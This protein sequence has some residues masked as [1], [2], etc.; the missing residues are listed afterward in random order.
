M[1]FDNIYANLSIIPVSASHMCNT[2]TSALNEF[3]FM[4]YLIP[5][6]LILTPIVFIG[7]PKASHASKL[8]KNPFP[9][10]NHQV[11][12]FLSNEFRI[13][14]LLSSSSICSHHHKIKHILP[15]LF[16]FDGLHFLPITNLYP[17]F[18]KEFKYNTFD[19]IFQC[20]RMSLLIL[21]CE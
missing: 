2:L 3:T 10:S 18:Y 12:T 4:Y 14:L 13:Y 16:R 7:T 21:Y 5:Y 8:H 1:F 20:S 19:N 15:P 9:R 6:L 11:R 17:H